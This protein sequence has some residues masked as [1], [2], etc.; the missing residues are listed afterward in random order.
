MNNNLTKNN[1]K[2]RRPRNSKGNKSE[3]IPGLLKQIRDLESYNKGSVFK[4]PVVFPDGRLFDSQVQNI[5]S[6]VELANFLTTSTVTPSFASISFRLAYVNDFASLT[7][8]FDQYRVKMMQVSFY[9]RQDAS[10]AGN[11]VSGLLHTVIDYDDNASLPNVAAALDYA[12][13]LITPGD[14]K[15]VRTF[16]PRVAVPLYAGAIA[17]GYGNIESPWIDAASTTVD[18]YGVKVAVPA[19]S[20]STIYDVIVRAWIQFRAQ[21]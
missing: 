6:S 16:I 8:V 10:T 18:H 4:D 15:Q 1:K 2:G 5:I 14:T 7:T 11:L 20:S 21:R 12:N 17:S 19:G 13:C 9:P 3:S